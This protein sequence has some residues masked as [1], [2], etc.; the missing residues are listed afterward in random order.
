MAM[1]NDAESLVRTLADSGVEVCFANPGTSEMHFASRTSRPRHCSTSA[2]GLGNGLANLHNAHTPD[3]VHRFDAD[4]RLEALP[5]MSQHAV[6]TP[7]SVVSRTSET[8]RRLRALL[9]VAVRVYLGQP[10][11][12]HVDNLHGAMSLGSPRESAVTGSSLSTLDW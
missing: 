1:M 5:M 9:R 4:V 8:T 3:V 12:S 2:P 7:S 6:S 11:Q 10:D